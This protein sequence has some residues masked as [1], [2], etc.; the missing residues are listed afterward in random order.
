MY[1]D[2]LTLNFESKR[3]TY[4]KCSMY[5]ATTSTLFYH[6]LLLLCQSVGRFTVSRYIYY[7]FAIPI[8]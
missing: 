6:E 3:L 2:L 7:D 8:L 1:I 5:C 4:S